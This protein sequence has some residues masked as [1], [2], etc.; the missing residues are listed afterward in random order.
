MFNKSF[1]L[2]HALADTVVDENRPLEA[3]KET[4]IRAGET[5]ENI[6]K[7]ILTFVGML[8]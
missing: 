6:P 5:R 4:R 8:D 2:K 1:A 3:S 7:F